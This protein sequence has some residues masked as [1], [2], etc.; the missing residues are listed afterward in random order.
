MNDYSLSNTVETEQSA[1][2]PV[3]NGLGWSALKNPRYLSAMVVLAGG[4]AVYCTNEFIT[5][6]VLP[7]LVRDIGGERYFAWATSLFVVASVVSS[8]FVPRIV[9]LW[10]A[11]TMYVVAIGVQLAGSVVC[12]L[13]P[14]YITF[15]VGRV[16]QGFSGGWLAALS[17]SM[18]QTA[19]PRVLWKLG[20]VIISLM[21]ALGTVVGPI[22]GGLAVE[23]ASWRWA[24]A[25]IGAM[26]VLLAV[27][28]PFG[29][30]A[31]A[32]TDD[33]KYPMPL[34][35]V[36]L[37]TV[38]SIFIS[39]AGV[40][41][42]LGWQI[43]LIVMS[44]L[45]FVALFIYERHSQARIFPVSMF[46][47]QYVTPWLYLSISVI[48]SVTA[49]VIFVPKFT[50]ELGGASPLMAGFVGAMMSLGWTP[51]EI[52][53]ARFSRPATIG[54]LMKISPVLIVAAF[55][56]CWCIVQAHVSTLWFVGLLTP[57]LFIFGCGVGMPWPHLTTMIL[58]SGTIGVT[59]L[60]PQERAI[61]ESCAATSI[62]TVQLMSNAI[63]AALAGLFVNCGQGVPLW[64]MQDL[65]IGF[66]AIALVCCV[67][68]TMIA[69]RIT[70]GTGTAAG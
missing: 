13:A 2:E 25:I 14:E 35:S 37:V 19:L 69:R 5:A 68:N 15:L 16:L 21:W 28:I 43:A 36:A 24:F 49:F 30:P 47:L 10:G 7:S 26:A 39:I 41:R 33:H 12:A 54:M 50:Q 53:S 67:T 34:V 11:R 27:Y 3:E 22:I 51:G 44:V 45:L 9:R 38:S 57:A 55:I 63:G 62:T 58:G 17:Y 29:I 61:N 48:S 20:S 56:G 8:I 31:H 1:P 6:S 46:S 64:E 40:H 18:V 42:V 52:F 66:S 60:S 65:I 23:Y 59:E 4:L 32:V 70:S